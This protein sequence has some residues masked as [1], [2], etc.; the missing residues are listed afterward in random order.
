MDK[1]PS[2]V[3]NKELYLKVKNEIVEKM[4]KSSAYRSGRIVREYKKRGGLYKGEKPD[5]GLSSWFK[6]E[7]WVNMREFL[8]GKKVKR[9]KVKTTG[10]YTG[11]GFCS[12]RCHFFMLCA[13]LNNPVSIVTFSIPLNINLLKVPLCFIW[14]K[15]DSISTKRRL[16]SVS[17]CGDL[18]FSLAFLRYTK[19][20]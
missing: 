7:K 16:L 17:P 14:P 9:K 19:S 8:K 18:K 6:E 13:K 11:T 3:V 2:N 10:F 15:T 1:V 12:V 20:L 4:P 5:G